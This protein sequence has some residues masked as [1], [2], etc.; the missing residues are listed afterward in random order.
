MMLIRMARP[1]DLDA[2]VALAR[3]ADIGV[4][5]LQADPAQLAERIERS[6]RTLRNEL[7]RANQGYLF[8]LECSDTPASW[9][10]HAALSRRWACI[11]PGT[12]TGW[13]R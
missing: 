8:V 10:A 13:A 3:L 4:T 2:L 6:Q 11:R 5:S 9:S 12:T 1:D 7:P